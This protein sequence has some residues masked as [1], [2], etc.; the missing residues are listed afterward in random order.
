M[1]LQPQHA[2]LALGLAVVCICAAV[3]YAV[4]QSR[5][6]GGGPTSEPLYQVA[7][8]E[9]VAPQVLTVPR[10][11]RPLPERVP[12]AVSPGTPPTVQMVQVYPGGWVW[13]PYWHDHY[14]WDH[15][16]GDNRR[17]RRW[18]ETDKWTYDDLPERD[19]RMNR[20]NDP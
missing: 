7:A 16:W 5:Q 8:P 15:R 1:E 6:A 13:N 12:I 11:P 20:R 19:H 10:A 18:K 2:W 9:Y 4:F 3:G 14:Y 17:P